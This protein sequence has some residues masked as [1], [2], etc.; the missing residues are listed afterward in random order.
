MKRTGQNVNICVA[1]AWALAQLGALE[2]RQL[3]ELLSA[4]VGVRAGARMVN[5]PSAELRVSGFLPHLSEAEQPVS[6]LDISETMGHVRRSH[7]HAVDA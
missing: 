3:P 5:A 7:T 2:P 6:D 1:A 4:V